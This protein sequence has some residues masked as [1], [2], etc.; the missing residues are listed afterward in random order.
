MKTSAEIIAESSETIISDKLIYL[1]RI[2]FKL[3]FEV[4]NCYN[5]F[6]VAIFIKFE[7]LFKLQLVKFIELTVTKPLEFKKL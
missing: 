5:K 3:L 6:E 7:L 4:I 2:W 1:K